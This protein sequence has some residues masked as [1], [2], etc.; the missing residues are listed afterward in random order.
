MAL[1]SSEVLSSGWEFKLTEE[2]QPDSWLPVAKVPTTVHIDLLDNKKILDPSLDMNELQTHWVGEKRWTY[3]CKFTAGSKVEGAKTVL[4]FEGLDTFATVRLNDTG[5]LKSE[6]MFIPYHVDVT[7]TIA[8][9]SL[10][11]IEID[12]ESALLRARE[13]GKEHPEHRFI[14]HQTEPER[15]AVRKT[16]CHWGWDWGPK[17][18]TAGPW[19]PVRLET[20]A[21]KIENLW[22]DSTLDSDLNAC[23]GNMFAHVDGE[24]GAKVLLTLSLEGTTVFEAECTPDSKGAIQTPFV[25]QKPSLWYPHGYGAQTRYVLEASL[26]IDGVVLHRVEQKIGFRRAELIQE[27]DPN[28]KSFYFRINGIDVFAG[29]SCWIPADNF[30]PRISSDRYRAWLTLMVEGNQI[31]TR[32]WGG[33]IFEEEVFYDVCD[34]LGILVWQDFLFACGSYPTYPSLL[35]SIEAEARSNVRRLRHHPS[36]II[37]AGGNEDYQIQQTYNLDYDYDG[38][39]DPESWLKSSF[40]SRY[41]FEY[42]LP[43][44]LAEEDPKAIYHPSSPWGDGKHTTDPTVGD[45]HQWDVWNGLMKPYQDFPIMGGRFN[46]EFG[47]E[48]YPHMSTIKAFISDE[49]EMHAQSLTMDFHNKA[50]FHERRLATYVHENFRVSSADFKYWVYLTQLLQSEAMHYAFTRWRRE[51]ERAGERRCGGALVWQLND[52]WPTISW[53]VVDYFLVKKPA[54]Y[55]I[56]RALKPVSITV[57]RTHNDWTKGHVAPDPTSKYDVWIASNNVSGVKTAKVELRFISIKT[58]LDV[59]DPQTE[60][61]EIQPN[62]TTTVRES[63]TIDNPPTL[64][65]F[66][67][68][69]TLSIDGEV[70]ARDADWP[71]PLKYLSFKEDRCLT[72][73]LSESRDTISITAEKPVK[74]LVFAERVGLNFSENGLDILPGHEYS[75]YVGG[76]KEDEELEWVFLGASESH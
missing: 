65:A 64:E 59:V 18:M 56:Q 6:N 27:K 17:L 30:T 69:A 28:G 12:F 25:L 76:L 21:S 26:I 71:Q 70:I 22:L 15:I 14:G 74:G 1:F 31:M 73:T 48:G 67:L 19:R 44:T 52:C 24:A 61:L 32:I 38:D 33:G 5:I 53:A 20:Y 9:N 10:N 75:I 47:M 58:G 2:T 29:G 60:D 45:I 37:Y 36:V 41:I 4:V 51:W 50:N 34:E 46:S 23:I 42:L 8:F 11:T 3:R 55:A 40:P 62:G 43:K 7:S 35:E 16:Q 49:S 63:V 72:I 39:K 68:F 13:I 57:A 54:F 66:V